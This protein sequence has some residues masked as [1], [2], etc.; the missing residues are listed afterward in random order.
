MFISDWIEADSVMLTSPSPSP[1]SSPS[2]ACAEKAVASAP[3]LRA[4]ARSPAQATVSAP[5]LC[6]GTAAAS[7]PGLRCSAPQWHSERASRQ[8]QRSVRRSPALRKPLRERRASAPALDRWSRLG[9]SARRGAAPCPARHGAGLRGVGWRGA[10][11]CRAARGRAARDRAGRS[12]Q[13]A[14]AAL[15]TLYAPAQLQTPSRYVIRSS[16]PPACPRAAA[17]WLPGSQQ[18][19][20]APECWFHAI[21]GSRRMVFLRAKI[22][23]EEAELLYWTALTQMAHNMAQQFHRERDLFFVACNDKD[24]PNCRVDRVKPRRHTSLDNTKPLYVVEHRYGFTPRGDAHWQAL[25]PRPKWV[26][27]LHC[28]RGKVFCTA[29]RT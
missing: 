21:I 24:S 22:K 5:G 4:S 28:R 14:L 13:R 25:S 8:R 12:Y 20:S 2:I 3:G 9:G 15:A 18:L 6:Y 1:S 10:G 16:L 23:A 19:C 29:S 26:W 27:A 7:A 11:L 17:S